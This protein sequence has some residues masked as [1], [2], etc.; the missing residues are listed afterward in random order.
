MLALEKIVIKE[1]LSASALDHS[2]TPERKNI[3]TNTTNTTS[4]TNSSSRKRFGSS[5]KLMD[6]YSG[7]RGVDGVAVPRKGMTH[8]FRDTANTRERTGQVCSK[9]GCSSRAN[10]PKVAQVRSSE[11]GKSVRPLF[12]SSSTSKEEI[13]SSSRSTSNPAKRN[14]EPRKIL[15]SQFE[16]DSPESS[17]VQDEPESSE[18]IPPSEEIQRGPKSRGGSSESSNVRLMEVGSSSSV[19]NTRSQ[20]NLNQRSGLR[21]QEIKSTGPVTHAVSS[22]YG[23]RNIRCNTIS[24]VIPSGC[25]SSDSSHNRRKDTI[26]KRDGEGESSS[27]VRGK[28]IIGSSLEGRNSGSRNG[29]SISDSR[30]TRNTFSH[31][32]TSLT[33]VRTQRSLSGHARGRLS[34][35]GNENPLA[36][37]NSSEDLPLSPPA[38]DDITDSLNGDNFWHYNMSSIEGV[39]LALERIEQGGEL[40]REQILMFGTDIY[41]NGLNFYDHH[42]DM[43]LDIDNMSYEE[44]LALEER[45][46]T[47]STALS[48]EAL[49]ESLKRSIYQSPPTH[50][51]HE[52]CNE[53]KDDIKC[54]IC[55]EE[56]V[57]GDEVGDLPCKH[58]FHVDCIQ[59]WMGLKNWCPICKLSAALSNNS[60]SPH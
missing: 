2:H 41:E 13:G 42:R 55:Q 9:L 53:D 8:V 6:E 57:I 1:M 29:I 22:R 18:L 59:E 27:T 16:A 14:T 52:N 19:S 12:Q 60:S 39:V 4:T 47:V 28:N 33:P 37:S 38:E 56:Y 51:T 32:N 25:S 49:A 31:R 26:K 11:K 7:R 10:I 40:T 48:E 15:S 50:D 21:G 23:L 5:K 17:S 45:M 24:D 3:T 54:C 58:R 35:Q 20:R 34:S 36:T 30:R 46:G 43:R 44:L